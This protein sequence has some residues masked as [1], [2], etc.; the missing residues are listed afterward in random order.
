MSMGE[1]IS[2][3]H[4]SYE[5][6]EIALQ[7]FLQERFPEED[8]IELLYINPD[9]DD[10]RQKALTELNKTS[11]LKNQIGKQLEHI[12]FNAF[13]LFHLDELGILNLKSLL[14][15]ESVMNLD[16]AHIIVE[17][18]KALLNIEEMEWIRA[19]RIE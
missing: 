4:Y 18:F 17:R 11:E 1:E 5:M 6:E 19:D 9:S 12:N 14:D 13:S 16:N 3:F 15:A 7:I 10:I 8:V 2:Q